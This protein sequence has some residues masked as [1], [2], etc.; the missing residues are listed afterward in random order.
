MYEVRA[1]HPTAQ[2]LIYIL[3]RRYKKKEST[4]FEHLLFSSVKKIRLCL[5]TGPV[6]EGGGHKSLMDS[7]YDAT[8]RS[9]KGRINHEFSRP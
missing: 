3:Y 8:R 4:S 7:V 6:W 9:K 5:L 1:Y 2:I